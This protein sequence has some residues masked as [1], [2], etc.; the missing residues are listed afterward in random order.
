MAAMAA[1][2]SSMA[3][4]SLSSKSFL[5]QLLPPITLPSL[6]PGKSTEKQCPIVM[7]LKRWERKECKPNSL[8]ILH[9][10][11]VKLGDTVQVISGRERGKVGEITKIFK[12]NSTVI[13]KDLNLKTKHV[14]SR[15]EGEPG[16]IIKIEGPIHSSNVMLYSKDQ[17]VASRVGH[18]VLDNGKKVR[19]LIKT[20]EII[21]S[22]EN[23]K[24]LKE[25]TKKS[26][27]AAA[28]AA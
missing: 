24:K 27:E 17:K 13:V 15:E 28:A 26:E 8:P 20:G 7:R 23:W 6:L 4:L 19:Y 1:L 9:K 14:K 25:A 18:K 12:H 22:S 5:G 21:D 16:Q 10:M 3:G 2:Q 11:H